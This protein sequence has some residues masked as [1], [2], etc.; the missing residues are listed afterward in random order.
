M[1]GYKLSLE[2]KNPIDKFPL[3]DSFLNA[4]RRFNLSTI[5]QVSITDLIPAQIATYL[6][7]TRN[8]QIIH[9]TYQNVPDV[10]VG[11]LERAEP[12]ADAKQSL[13]APGHARHYNRLPD[14]LGFATVHGDGQLLVHSGLQQLLQ[15]VVVLILHQ[16]SHTQTLKL[17][18]RS[19]TNTSF[20]DRQTDRHTYQPGVANRH[21]E[22]EEGLQSSLV[23]GRAILHLQHTTQRSTSQHQAAHSTR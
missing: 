17:S 15:R 11:T 2:V 22:V 7:T 14:R 3:A 8:I 23:S 12:Y 9:P 21:D 4:A 13:T 18:T 1:K 16:P 19:Q 10:L 20:N 6:Q 5:L